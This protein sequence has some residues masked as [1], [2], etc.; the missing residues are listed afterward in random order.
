MGLAKVQM[1]I[2]PERQFPDKI[3]IMMNRSLARKLQIS[4]HSFPV[5]FGSAAA[6]AYISFVKSNNN[7]I[8][9]SSQ[10]ADR[11][12]ITNQPIINVHFDPYA[13]HLW[14]GPLL[15][16]LVNVRYDDKKITKFLEECA[17]SGE[18][19]G[20]QVAVFTPEQIYLEEKITHAFIRED[21][22]W[23][24]AYLP[25]PDVIYNRI[26]LRKVEQRE[27]VQKKLTELK[28]RH[29]IFIFNE[30]FL[31]KCEVHQILS[32]DE[33]I[34][35]MLPETYPFQADR[36][37]EMLHKYPM[38]YLK[39]TNGSLGKGIMRVLHDNENWICQSS[40]STGT[41]TRTAKTLAQMTTLL[42][43]QIKR[44]PYLIQ[45]GL[46]LAKVKGDRPLDFRV[47]VQKNKVGRWQIT[48]SVGRVANNQQIVSNVA[49]GGTIRKCTEVLAEL[50]S[51][52]HKPTALDLQQK[53]LKIAHTFER[54]EK[55][56]FAELGIDLAIDTSGKI[57]LIEINSKPSKTNNTI[58]NQTLTTRPSVARMIE[59]VNYLA[60]MNQPRNRSL[61]TIKPHLSQPERR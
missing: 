36:V 39:P 47:L 40:S 43:K 5:T 42:N 33:E 48:S 31:D 50:E 44:R 32:K 38:V 17:I 13:Q 59:Y 26:T 25:L 22:E 61:S 52:P 9:M 56:H 19:S 7:L 57:W 35:T 27:E 53:A 55:G 8:R 23:K 2:L 4:I 41:I 45:Q 58:R 14:F 6:M 18:I 29:G 15:G 46:Q 11:L 49:H 34:R 12:K 30:K 54:L 51:I 37:K 24:S 1:Q 16:I 10:L 3:N 60:K 28:N 20:V 21:G